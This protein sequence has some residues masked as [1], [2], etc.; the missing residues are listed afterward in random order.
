MTQ[1]LQNRWA[2]LATA[3]MLS[4]ALGAVVVIVVSA[5]GT[6]AS[7]SVGDRVF[8]TSGGTVQAS[9][10]HARIGI[11]DDQIAMEVELPLSAAEAVAAGWKDPVYCS[12]GRGRYF[13]KDP[14]GEGQPYVL[15]FS[16]DDELIG[17]YQYS[18]AE[19]PLPWR[20]Q[21][22]LLGGGG[23]TLIDFE[24]WSLIVY[25]Q[26]PTLACGAGRTGGLAA[27]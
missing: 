1:F 10:N 7:G 17:M 24:H 3:C 2:Q 6:S 5:G 22:Q 9:G 27:H 19:M 15:M 18:R 16:H 13:Q 20:R 25:F 11:L 21:D 12:S 8:L 14:A 23:L 4:A 26:D